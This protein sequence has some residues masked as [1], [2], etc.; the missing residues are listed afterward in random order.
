MPDGAPQRRLRNLRVLAVEDRF[1][2]A[3][4]LTAMLQ[5]LGCVVVGPVARPQEGLDLL[6]RETDG[7]GAA[8]LDID[9][10]GEPVY[11]LASELLRQRVPIV[12]ATGFSARALPE[13]WRRYPRVQKPFATAGLAQALVQ[14]L[15]TALPPTH[16]AALVHPEDGGTTAMAQPVVTQIW[17]Q[18]RQARNQ[19]S[20]IQAILETEPKQR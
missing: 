18:L 12:F 14:T 19:L 7:L 9:L 15:A 17:D 16:A 8:V 6:A 1:V 4:R 5:N 2:V 11:P 20:E 3:Q 10:N 13:A